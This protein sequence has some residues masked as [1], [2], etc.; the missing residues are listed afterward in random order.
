[1]VEAPELEDERRARLHA[2]SVAVKRDWPALPGGGARTARMD[3]SHISSQWRL[4]LTRR[5]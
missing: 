1:V 3:I 2:V 5:V 4:L